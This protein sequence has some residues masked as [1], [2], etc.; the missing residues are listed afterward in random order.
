MDDRIVE[1]IQAL[2]AAGVRVSLAESEDSMR[3]VEQ[4]GIIDR[5]L[6]KSALRTTLVKEHADFPTFEQ[7]F[8]VFFQIGPPPMQQPG[9][10]RLS[11]EQQAQLDAAMQQLMEQL[12]QKLREL[13]QRLM[14]GESLT[15]EELEAMAQQSG[16]R[17]DARDRGRQRRITRAADP[18]VRRTEPREADGRGNEA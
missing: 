15:R 10:N 8:P 5:E 6:F 7:M 14:A 1:F 16:A 17:T 9:A 3:A 12:S 2:R 18:A 11:E 13:L 4:L